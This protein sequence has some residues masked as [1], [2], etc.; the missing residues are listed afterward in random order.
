MTSRPPP[1]P[2]R[3]RL[4]RRTLLSGIP[5]LGAAALAMSGCTP[6]DAGAATDVEN[7][8]PI[9]LNQTETR[10]TYLALSPFGEQ[11]AA[12]PEG[13]WGARVYANESLGAQQEV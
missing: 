4:A 8:L 6:D 10:P 13:R 1:R 11:L 3:P 5:L 9:S 2:P 12:A 7:I